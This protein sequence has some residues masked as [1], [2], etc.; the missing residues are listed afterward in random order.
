MDRKHSK[1]LMLKLIEQKKIEGE[2][3]AA[4]KKI[5]TFQH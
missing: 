5:D 4:S 2:K 1:T 3:I